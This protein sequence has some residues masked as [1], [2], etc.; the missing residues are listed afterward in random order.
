MEVDPKKNLVAGIIVAHGELAA[1]LLKTAEV[2]VGKVENLFPIS[3]S[4]L[5]DEDIVARIKEIISRYTDGKVLIFV[6]YFGSSC[7]TNSIKAA[8]GLENAK[9]VSG[10]NLPIILDFIT[11]RELYDFD[12][13]IR[14][15]IERGRESVRLVEF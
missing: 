3:G 8:H 13:M 15:I 12:V 1:E 2:V 10:V 4:S 11:K 14:H 9:V 6:D 5:T 7:C